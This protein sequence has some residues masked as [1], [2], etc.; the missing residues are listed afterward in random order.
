MYTRLSLSDPLA[1]SSL[2]LGFSVC[3][4]MSG[5][6]LVLNEHMCPGFWRPAFNHTPAAHLPDSGIPCQS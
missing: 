5:L 1:S 4:V 2:V 6:V 3:A